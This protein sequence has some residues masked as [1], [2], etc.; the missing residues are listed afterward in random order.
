MNT[1]TQ[2]EQDRVSQSPIR[3][4]CNRG[5]A[6]ISMATAALASGA[7]TTTVYP[8]SYG[9]APLAG[10]T[11]TAPQQAGATPPACEELPVKL[12]SRVKGTPFVAY[13]GLA[14]DIAQ[15]AQGGITAVASGEQLNGAGPGKPAYWATTDLQAK[16]KS[17]HGGDVYIQCKQ[18]PAGQGVE[19]L[20]IV[21]SKK[22]NGADDRATFTNVM[23]PGIADTKKVHQVMIQ[24]AGLATQQGVSAEFAGARVAEGMKKVYSESLTTF[25]PGVE[26]Y[27]NVERSD[28][29]ML[30]CEVIDLNCHK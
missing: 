1:L 11:N 8:I 17:G 21:R 2:A 26:G 5:I 15:M 4:A 14:S 22:A 10:Q 27:Q 16:K 6:A 29:G 20:T 25:D 28:T 30:D 13:G 12:E 24:A 9:G 23:I 19:S 18:I 7:C 3:R